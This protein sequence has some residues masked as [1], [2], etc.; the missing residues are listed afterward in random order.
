[1][2]IGGDRDWSSDLLRN[3]SHDWGLHY[4]YASEMKL[5]Q[6]SGLTLFEQKLNF[7]KVI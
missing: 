6:F 1:M 7:R 5:L 4:F 2:M 3:Y